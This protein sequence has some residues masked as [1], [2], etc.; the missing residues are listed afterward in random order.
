MSFHAYVGL[1]FLAYVTYD[2]VT[3]QIKKYQVA[4]KVRNW[5]RNE[6]LWLGELSQE[7]E[8]EK[9]EL[10]ER[11]R[12]RAVKEMCTPVYVGTKCEKSVDFQLIRVKYSQRAWGSKQRNP[13]ALNRV[14]FRTRSFLNYFHLNL[15]NYLHLH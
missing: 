12:E 2:R 6:Q 8:C 5:Q 10:R 15:L 4:N 13:R 3:A 1:K 14:I 11:E 9:E 7:A